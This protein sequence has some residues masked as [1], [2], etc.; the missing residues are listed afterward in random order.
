[1]I[2]KYPQLQDGRTHYDVFSPFIIYYNVMFGS[3]VNYTID[4]VMCKK[5]ILCLCCQ[6]PSAHAQ[7]AFC[8]IFILHRNGQ[9]AQ[10]KA[11]YKYKINPSIDPPIHPFHPSILC[12]FHAQ[13]QVQFVTLPCLL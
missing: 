4:N 2:V 7:H 11:K 3:F 8:I 6:T 1:M 12:G 10:I 9:K 13:H 5:K